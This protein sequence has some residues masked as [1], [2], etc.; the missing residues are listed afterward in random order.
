MR[1]GGQVGTPG[2]GAAKEG[3]DLGCGE[4]SDVVAE[5]AVEDAS[6]ALIMDKCHRVIFS[7]WR[8]GQAMVMAADIP[9][10][11]AR[12][13]GGLSYSVYYISLVNN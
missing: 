9:G 8:V 11:F 4:G 10:R 12:P 13:R 1:G 6:P 7:R 2:G 5:G 3:L